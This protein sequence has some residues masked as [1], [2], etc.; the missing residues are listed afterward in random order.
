[1]GSCSSMSTDWG[2]TSGARPPVATTTGCAPSSTAMR[3]TMPS[4]MLRPMAAGGV[5]SSTR[6]SRAARCDRA[7][8]PLSTPGAITPP[9]N[10]PSADT[11][12][13]VVAV[14]KS[15]TTHGPPCRANAATAL[16]MRSAPTSCGLSTSSGMPVRTPGPT[17]TAGRSR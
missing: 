1:M 10:S 7:S 16:A 2:M 15:T 12:S 14:P 13:S 17:T 11:T 5:A 4:T 3:L 8:R 9:R 6:I